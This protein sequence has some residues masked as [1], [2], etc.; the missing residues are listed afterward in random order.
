MSSSTAV[1]DVLSALLR[2]TKI[3]WLYALQYSSSI[4]KAR[5]RIP[6]QSMHSSLAASRIW[7]V[8]QRSRLVFYCQENE[9][10]L[11][12]EPAG[13]ASD[14]QCLYL[15]TI[16][17]HLADLEYGYTLLSFSMCNS[18]AKMCCL[19]QEFQAF[20]PPCT[21]FSIGVL[22][23]REIFSKPH[24]ARQMDTRRRLVHKTLKLSSD[25]ISTRSVKNRKYVRKCPILFHRRNRL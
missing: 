20:L 16:L 17:Y 14:R 7:L 8:E 10:M 12:V 4:S 23:K 2:S 5:A 3:R 21:L 9:N 18:D 6:F 11:T 1:N 15:S 25:G 19:P 13:F 24:D 22:L